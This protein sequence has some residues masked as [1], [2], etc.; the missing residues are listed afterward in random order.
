MQTAGWII[1]G[2]ALADVVVMVLFLGAVWI[3]H[4]SVRRDA[5]KKGEAVASVAR[6]FGCIFVAFVAGFVLLAGAGL[7]LLSF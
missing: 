3:A 5:A 1:L 6:D 2:C 7:L 4:R